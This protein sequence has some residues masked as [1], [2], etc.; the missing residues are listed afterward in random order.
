M[1]DSFRYAMCN[2]AFEGW[3]FG[4][5]CRTLARLGY[6]GIEIAPFTLAADPLDVSPGQRREYRRQI[7]DEGLDFVGLHWLLV[8]PKQIHVSTPDRALREA[9]WEY[10]RNLIDLCA[11]LAG[12]GSGNGVMVFG[13]PKQRSS[14]GGLTSAEAA[15]N[16]VDGLAGVAPH[17]ESRG[18]TI[19]MEAL[20]HSQSDVVH[21]LAEAAAVV[22][23]IDSPAVRTMFDCH[24][25]EDETEPHGELIGKYFSLIRHV[26]VNEMDGGHPGTGDYDFVGIFRSLIE[27]KYQYWVSLESFDFKVGAEKI[28]SETIA[29]LRKQ[30]AIARQ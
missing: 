8:T 3:P 23:Q 26:H 12:N 11:D 10:V 9:S 30:E 16:F 5:V 22:N 25:A 4:D 14:T 17:A 6:K 28:A 27:M 24:N 15:R 1:P 7:L 21:T 13:S 18:V 20:P 19:L 2:E 29:Y